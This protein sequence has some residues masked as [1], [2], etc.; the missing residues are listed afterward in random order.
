MKQ[1]LAQDIALMRY[2]MISPL[3]VGL[4]DEYRSKAAYFRAASARGALHPNGSFI[5]PAPTSFKRWYQHYQKNGFDALLPSSR[6]DEGTSRKIDPDL[7]EQ[8]RYLKTTYPRMSA[9]AIFRQLCTNGSTNRNELS[10]STVNR[11]LNNLALKE[12]TTNNQDMRRYERAHVNEVW[13][14]DSSVGPYLKTEDGKKHK[15]YVIA[16]IDDASRYIVGIDVF[17]NDNF[18][19]LM[20]V[21]KSAVA[22][23][24]VPKL[25]KLNRRWWLSSAVIHDSVHALHFIHDPAGHLGKYLPGDLCSFCC[26]EIGSIYGSQCHCIIIGAF[27]THNTNTSHIGKGCE[28]LAKTL[29]HTGFGNL[30]TVDCI[31]VLNDTNLLGSNL[32][33]DTDSKTGAGERLTVYEVLRNT[34]FETGTTNL[35]LEQKPQ[36]LNNLLEIYIIRQS[37][38]VVMGFDYSALAKTT[39]DHIRINGT[40]YQ[41]IYFTDLLGLFLED[42]DKLFTNDLSLS[43][44]LFHTGKLAVE[45]L[46]CI[47]TDKVQVIRAV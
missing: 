8:I 3:I 10:E 12:K 29:V 25:F 44:R 5:H 43:F 46:L 30:L 31:C 18:V 7:E 13:C 11:F 38:Y 14:G 33:N 36:R 1:E 22:K 41:E 20:S 42:T 37:T 2:S 45:T 34:K 4:P 9:A 47:H 28:V 6:S 16:L 32:S 35:V 19:N 27:I 15:V 17:F 40:L 24:G 26:H 21:M 39:L 23:F